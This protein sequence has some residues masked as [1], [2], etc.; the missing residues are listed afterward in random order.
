LEGVRLCVPVAEELPVLLGVV[1]RVLE[2]D[3]VRL[4]VGVRL[5]VCVPVRLRDAV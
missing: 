2:N 5:G 4:A 1:V 3:P